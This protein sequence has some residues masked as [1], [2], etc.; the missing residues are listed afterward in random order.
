[1]FESC[2]D[3]HRSLS[4]PHHIGHDFFT[5]TQAGRASNLQ[6]WPYNHKGQVLYLT[7]L[8]KNHFFAGPFHHRPSA[9]DYRTSLT[10]GP[11]RIRAPGLGGD[12]DAAPHAGRLFVGTSGFAYPDWTPRFY[13]PGLGERDRLA[14]YAGRLPA[15]ELNNTFYARP[16]A[17]RI[18]AWAAATPATFRF[19]VKAQR[20]AAMRALVSSPVESAAWLT[21]HLEDFGQRLGAVLFRVPENLHRHLDGVSDAALG[22]LLD[23]WPRAVPLVMEFQHASW[24]V[25]ETFAA[26]RSVGAVLCATDL[27]EDAE[28]PTIRRTGDALYLR[29]RRHDYTDAELDVWA[30]RIEPFLA[31]SHPVFAFFRH[32]ETGR[33]TELAAGLSSRLAGYAEP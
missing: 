10:A 21:D 28:P 31:A 20:G 26:L 29:L 18:G 30:A 23:A 27:P 13:P 12:G 24:H 22:R 33:A 15:L 9:P 32:D 1:M 16:T 14:F 4:S 5:R 19:V 2:R 17:A 7:T 25:D 8:D 6:N 3:R 11:G